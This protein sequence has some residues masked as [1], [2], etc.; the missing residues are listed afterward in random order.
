MGHIYTVALRKLLDNVSP[1]GMCMC[2][3]LVKT[4]PHTITFEHTP[5]LLFFSP[6]PRRVLILNVLLHSTAYVHS[7]EK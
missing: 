6:H 2:A 1:H 4:L 5:F 3:V 7:K